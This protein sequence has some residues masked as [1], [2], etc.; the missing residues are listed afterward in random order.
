MK[1]VLA[2]I[3]LKRRTSNLILLRGVRLD[4]RK[5]FYIYQTFKP[6]FYR[7]IKNIY[8]KKLCRYNIK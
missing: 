1:T 7:S 8:Y 6:F 2:Y 4:K 5:V 3:K